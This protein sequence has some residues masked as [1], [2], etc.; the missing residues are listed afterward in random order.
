MKEPSFNISVKKII[1]IGTEFFQDFC[2]KKI[3]NNGTGFF[4]DFCKRIM[5]IET[6][7]FQDFCKYNTKNTYTLDSNI[8]L[9]TTPQLSNPLT[10]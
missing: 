3:I 1:N 6:G 7:F 2:E 4:Q 9:Y 10:R 5:D 8:E